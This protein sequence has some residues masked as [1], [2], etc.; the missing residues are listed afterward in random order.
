MA[1][2]R[3]LQ[4]DLETTHTFIAPPSLQCILLSS[5]NACRCVCLDH[6]IPYHSRCQ[7]FVYSLLPP[8]LHCIFNLSL[9]IL[10]YL[11]HPLYTYHLV[12]FWK[13]CKFLDFVLHDYFNL[14]IHS[15]FPLLEFHSFLKIHGL[16]ISK[17]AKESKI[18]L[19]LDFLIKFL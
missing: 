8:I 16:T 6:E 13:C 1:W 10:L 7:L 2:L 4:L 15:I 14:F 9:G 18:V 5:D 17:E 11:E 12:P 19:I 3:Y